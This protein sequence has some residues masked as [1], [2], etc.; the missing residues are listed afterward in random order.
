MWTYRSDVPMCGKEL[1]QINQGKLKWFYVGDGGQ[2]AKVRYLAACP[3]QAKRL[4]VLRY[5][6]VL[7]T[8]RH[9]SLALDAI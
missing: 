5:K 7:E 3:G 8:Q 2:G 9:L 4:C 1:K 6:Q